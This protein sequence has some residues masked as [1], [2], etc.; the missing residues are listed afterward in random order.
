M[1]TN[2]SRWHFWIDRG[3]TFTDIIGFDPNGATH[4]LKLL[5]ENS[6]NYDDAAI[7]GIRRMLH[8]PA[9]ERL[10]ARRIGSV[11]MGTTVATNA[12]LE[13]KGVPVAL[14]ITD[15]LADQLEIGTQAR[16]DIFALRIEKPDQLYAHVVSA[17][18]RVRADGTIETPLDTFNLEENLHAVYCQG[19]RAV[20]IVFMHAYAYPEHERIAS[21]IARDIGF[22]QISVSHEVA[23]LIKVLNRGDT[24]V[25]DAYLSP[26]L[27]TYVDRIKFAFDCDPDLRHTQLLFMTSSGGLTAAET[28]RGRDAI[29]SGPAGG[30]VAMA[31]TAEKLGY[32]NVIGFDM[33]GTSTDVTHYAGTFERSLETR[34]SNVRLYV[35]MLAVETVAAGGGSRIV[36]DNGRLR[37]GPESAGADP[38]PACYRKGG[39]LTVTDAN[40]M[41]GKLNP[42]WFPYVFGKDGNLPLDRTIVE[43]KFETLRRELNTALS[44]RDLADGSIQIAVENMANA[45]KKITIQ[46]GHDVAGYALQC[47]G[48]AAG[49]HA[50]QVADRLGIS[51]ILIHP[52]S[53]LLS[54]YGM[55]LAD[56]RTA[57]TASIE[58]PLNSETLAGIET[59]AARLARR[60]TEKLQAMGV[61]ETD[62]T[63]NR[64][65]HIRY[66]G[67]DTAL[68]VALSD[69]DQMR[70]A[71]KDKHLQTYGYV[72]SES[73]IE[74]ALLE[75]AASGGGLDQDSEDFIPQPV[76]GD[77]PAAE[78]FASTT[79]FTQQTEHNT[80]AFRRAD[81]MPGICLSG[82]AII[83]EEHQTVVVEPG[84]SAMLSNQRTL[85][86]KRTTATE[87]NNASA[88]QDPI[89]LEIFNNQFQAIAEQMGV[90][91]AQTARS[92]N[93]KERLDFSCAIFDAKGNLIANAPHVP[94]HLGSMDR[95][96][97]TILQNRAGRIEPNSSFMLNAPY[98]GGTH[99]PDIT[100]ITPVF[101][102][103]QKNISFFTAS[104]GHHADIGGIAPGSMS[105]T[106]KT[107][108][109]EGIV[110]DDV[111]IVRENVFLEREIYALLT[112]GPYPARNPIQN[113]A[114]L[115]A[116]L[117]ANM[118]GA[119]N[120]GEMVGRYGQ[121][122]V[123]AYMGYVQDNAEQ[124]VRELLSRLESGQFSVEMDNGTKINVRV[125]VDKFKQSATID[126]TGTSAQTTDN[127]NAPEPVTRAAVLYVIRVLL[128]KKIPINA[129]C[130]RPLEILIPD[131]S[132]LKPHPPAA[133]VAGNVET[134]QV[135]TNALF[136]TFGA[137][138]SSQGTMN[139]L[140]FGD[141][142]YQYYETICSGSPAGPGFDGVAA[143]QVHMTNTR[144]TDPEVLETRYPVVVDEFSIR[145]NS[146]G[147]GKWRAGDGTRRVIRFLEPMSVAILSGSRIKAPF[148]L[149]G[150]A[151]G[152]PGRNHLLRA[153]GANVPLGGC[154]DILV[155]SGDRVIIE[156]PTGGGFGESQC[157]D[158][159]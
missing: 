140:T 59:R 101:D 40:V 83:T 23:P 142:T 8:V 69:V 81:L 147:E 61:A 133:V 10:P 71:F 28:F 13:R 132:I 50:C 32:R 34:V 5:S 93:I 89:L 14:V 68:S 77:M 41:V 62:I 52:L 2:N 103:A 145:R 82:P 153:D 98:Q 100:V 76:E 39:P 95:A 120:L 87:R 143:V 49:Q 138:S 105:P 36:I 75:V 117:A 118:R 70:L 11:R 150:G 148:G 134:S 12:L 48:A 130:L 86:L 45:I 1:Q 57:E 63:V 92:V 156:S 65:V 74:I 114:D 33:G 85:V 126:F 29:L 51:T 107:I 146:G 22:T 152:Q 94:V 3:G 46:R 9:G 80:P 79:I 157:E 151:S 67:S 15:G 19:I 53:G 31:K 26:I 6:E 106:G 104:R 42:D 119:S 24:T 84:W 21:D 37:V 112:A 111:Q 78:P 54:A 96:V 115:K 109:E 122:V 47:F 58:R 25:A 121:D 149:N 135:V 7:E 97:K 113:I 144:L 4:A 110:I 158:C 56:L 30:V 128:G 90:V 102:G 88:N 129:G 123:H 131:G 55:G 137:L 27:K 60:V 154:A 18:E 125:T 16:P 99:L 141:D 66:K 108:N 136:A 155:N 44:V 73:D 116:Q 159:E 17:K 91:L 64:S 139:N 72:S 20:A 35:P 124:A 127:F 38:G 43:Q